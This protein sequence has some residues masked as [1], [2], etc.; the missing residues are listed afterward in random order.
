M[1]LEVKSDK[2]CGWLEGLS[3]LT[4]FFIYW[5]QLEW[6]WIPFD[7]SDIR[8][9]KW[10]WKP[11]FLS[12]KEHSW[13]PEVSYKWRAEGA[14]RTGAENATGCGVTAAAADCASSC[15]A[16]SV[17]RART[18]CS[19]SLYLERCLEQCQTQNRHWPSI[20]WMNQCLSSCHSKLHWVG[21]PML[22]VSA[23]TRMPNLGWRHSVS[24]L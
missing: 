7:I 5:K 14:W 19:F 10:P 9:V 2:T 3:K 20:C 13:G 23:S 11:A 17:W 16:I 21:N 4:F 22:G 12:R 15:Q 8:A 6:E 1:K 18:P 24:V